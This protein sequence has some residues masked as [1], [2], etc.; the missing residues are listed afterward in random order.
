MR[1]SFPPIRC[2]S[3]A[4]PHPQDLL[5]G[6][7]PHPVGCGFDLRIGAGQVYPEVNFT[8]PPILITDETWPH[9]LGHHEEM[10]QAIVRR[11]VAL[12][13][14]GLVLEFEHLPPM[15]ERPEWGAEI[16]ALLLHHLQEARGVH[17]LRSALRVTPAD[18]RDQRRPPVLRRGAH[19]ARLARGLR[20]LAQ[21]AGG[22]PLA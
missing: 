6:C 3:L 7:S 12:R 4:I 2:T 10:A 19:L 14:P 18:L 5:F 17:G 16:T 15:T 13:V 22:D 21:P 9:V 8:L 20:P 11:V 1:P